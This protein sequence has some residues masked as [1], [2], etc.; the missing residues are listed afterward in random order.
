MSG[1][2]AALGVDADAERL[3]RR[4]LRSPPAGL[5]AH[6]A[7]LGWGRVHAHAALQALAAAGLVA[8]SGGGVLVADAPRVA[9]GRLIDREAAL[10]DAR[11]TELD[12]A[13]SV[14]GDFADERLVDTPH[15]GEVVA[16]EVVPKHLVVAALEHA[17]RS[18]TGPIRHFIKSTST[19]PAR[20]EHL[21]RMV[22]GEVARGRSMRTIY[23]VAIMRA[24][25]VHGLLWLR[26]WADVGEQQRLMEEVPHAYTVFGDELVLSCTEW[27]VITNDLVA[28]RSRLLVQMFV[29]TFDEAWRVGLPVPATAG[30]SE[31][32]SRLLALLASGLKDEAIARYLGVSLRT[33]R[34][35]VAGLMEEMGAH[36]R[37]QLGLAAERRGLLTGTQRAPAGR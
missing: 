1:E 31:S 23:P 19:A 20:D 35:R 30:D 11:R 7:A 14:I 33:V 17:V 10:L 5:D 8:E 15:S 2:L 13:Q 27:G 26:D 36:T 3:Y 37:F 28:I 32:D 21:V 29:A 25:D 18:T 24:P 9:I 16:L 4:V 12:D 34:R 6:V 22:Q